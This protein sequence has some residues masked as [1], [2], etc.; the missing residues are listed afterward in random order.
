MNSLASKNNTAILIP[1]FN[2]KRTIGEV[3]KKC[4][5]YSSHVIC[6]DDGSNDGGPDCIKDLNIT[7]LKNEKNLGK[8][9]ALEKGF[10]YI[11]TKDEI[12]FVVTIDADLQHP[13]EKIPQFLQKANEFDVVIGNRMHNLKTM[14]IHRI[15]SNRITSFL[16]STKLGTKI[17]DSQSGFRCYRKK[18]L[19]CLM[20]GV[21][22]FEA[23]SMHLILAVR[24]G[25]SIGAVDIPVIYGNDSSKMRNF[26]ATI[27]FIKILFK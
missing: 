22:G 14:P 16:L 18:V 3:V 27:G 26:Q 7:L 24:N 21:R 20:S 5:E 11:L 9:A 25:F 15:M 1:F 23:E 19:P 8:G 17:P 12:E 4:F 6:V 13:P 2:E 10:K